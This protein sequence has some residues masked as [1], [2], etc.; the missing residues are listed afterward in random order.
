M[1]D[2]LNE[3]IEDVDGIDDAFGMSR[4]RHWAAESRADADASAL[5]DDEIVARWTEWQER[6]RLRRV[7]ALGTARP[8]SRFDE[9]PPLQSLATPHRVGWLVVDGAGDPYAG[10]AYVLRHGDEE[11]T[12]ASTGKDGRVS[13]DPVTDDDY[14]LEVV[15][16]DAA[17]WD[18]ATVHLGAP[19][20][21]HVRASGLD[22]ESVEVILY[23]ELREQEADAIARTTATVQDGV[24][25][26][27]W[28]PDADALDGAER[29][30]GCVRIIAEVRH[31]KTCWAKTEVPL[32]VALPEVV[33]ASWSAPRVEPG[34]AIELVACTR[35]LAAG[36]KVA[37][38]VWR[39]PFAGDDEHVG[40]VAEV[41]IADGQARAR[42]TAPDHGAGEY[43]FS[44]S[45]TEPA[46]CSSASALLVVG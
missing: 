24:A 2:P 13:R 7:H 38:D 5:D 17:R 40:T 25:V 43:W 41:A 28:T 23:V 35:G 19:A 1:M 10:V 27:T 9:A 16:I 34:A 32:A 14:S 45:V 30:D 12:R 15:A 3:G 8:E 44:A 22:G 29:V 6:P 42:W 20:L 26:V 46:V 11:L 4:M 18:G 31:G 21:L 37:F 33:D 36:A 39:V